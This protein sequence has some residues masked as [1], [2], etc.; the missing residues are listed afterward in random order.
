MLCSRT[1]SVYSSPTGSG[2]APASTG[3][4]SLITIAT[5]TGGYGTGIGPGSTESEFGAVTG[6]AADAGGFGSTN[7]STGSG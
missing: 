4:F 1:G 6:S 5:E 3:S 2:T 7:E